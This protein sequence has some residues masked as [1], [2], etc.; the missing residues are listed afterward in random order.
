M[1]RISSYSIYKCS[2]CEQ[3]H[4]LPNYASIS[5]TAA[6]DA[7][8]PYD[9]LRTCFG[10]GVAK[11]FKQFVLIGT[12]QKPSADLTPS[13]VKFFKR[14]FGIKCPDLE[15]HPTTEYPYLNQK[16]PLEDASFK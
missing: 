6:V 10:C 12:K 11:P 2:D 13:F 8:V 5:V 16:L 9:D 14:M 1:T 4:I 15:P 7:Y 3:C